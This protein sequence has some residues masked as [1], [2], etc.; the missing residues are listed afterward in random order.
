MAPNMALQRT[1]R[2]RI[3]SGRSLCSLGSPLSFWSLGLISPK[4]GMAASRH[5]IAYLAFGLAVLSTAL[6]TSCSRG[7]SR[8]VDTRIGEDTYFIEEARKASPPRDSKAN[9]RALCHAVKLTLEAGYD[10]WKTVPS[11][12]SP[13]LQAQEGEEIITQTIRMFKGA[14]S[15]EDHEAFDARKM[16]DLA[17]RGPSS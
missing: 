14:A 16:Q 11:G 17:C 3:R 1:R 15:P 12:R 8:F 10:Y 9:Q 6:L 5:Q 2:P 7:A 13:E 4:A